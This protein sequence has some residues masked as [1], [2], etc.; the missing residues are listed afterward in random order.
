MAEHKKVQDRVKD[1]INPRVF[2]QWDLNTT[3]H[4]VSPCCHSEMGYLSR[5]ERCCM[6][7]G[8]DRVW[9]REQEV[10]P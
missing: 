3:K 6:A 4:D 10:T 2:I 9:S 5:Y 7:S 1:R 8:C